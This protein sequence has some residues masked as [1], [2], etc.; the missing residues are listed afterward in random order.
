[1]HKLLPASCARGSPGHDFSTSLPRQEVFIQ[2][3]SR[4]IL[5]TQCT[6]C[7]KIQTCNSVSLPVEQ[8]STTLKGVR[9]TILCPWC[10]TSQL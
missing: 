1:M 7:I 5:L 9:A 8:L 6:K 4:Y 10:T 2:N 3:V